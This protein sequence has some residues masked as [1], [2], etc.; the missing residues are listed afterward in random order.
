MRLVSIFS[1]N[2]PTKV[3]RGCMVY[4]NEL[5]HGESLQI[6]RC[7]LCSCNDSNIKCSIMDCPATFCNDPLVFTKECC[8]L[9]PYCKYMGIKIN[10]L[11]IPCILWISGM[12]KYN[13]GLCFPS[14]CGFF[15][16]F[17]F[18]SFLWFGF[19]PWVERS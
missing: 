1:V 15:F 2:A 11:C 18:F 13:H 5:N 14:P 17:F 9:C 3:M 8:A 12:S 7:T 16:L 4:G 10:F 19:F 6:D